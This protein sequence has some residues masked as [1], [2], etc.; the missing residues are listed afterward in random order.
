MLTDEDTAVI[1]RSTIELGHNLGLEVVAEGVEDSAT[2]QA[3]LP[4]GCDVLQGYHISRPMPAEM[5]ADWLDRWQPPH[6]VAEHS[7]PLGIHGITGGP[8][9]PTQSRES[10]MPADESCSTAARAT[11]PPRSQPC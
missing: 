4:L 1:V 9:L 8:L 3:L 10:N 7:G 5:T 11:T 6:I 2:W